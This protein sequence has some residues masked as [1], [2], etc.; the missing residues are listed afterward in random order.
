MTGKE[1]Y[2]K[3]LKETECRF[4]NSPIQKK[5]LK[6]D[7][8]WYYSICST[9]IKK[10]LPV[11]FGINPGAKDSVDYKIKMEMP[12]T[13]NEINDY[14]FIKYISPFLEEYTNLDLND[15]NFNYTNLCFFRSHSIRDLTHVDYE[16]SIP[17]FKKYL[18]YINP[19]YIL[20]IGNK[21]INVL[22]KVAKKS[23]KIVDIDIHPI[24]DSLKK[25][26]AYSGRLWGWSLYSVPHPN[27]HIQTQSR[28]ELWGKI[29]HLIN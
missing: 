2:K 3:L 25:Y 8:E 12:T 5:Q 6:N 23:P 14:R 4:Q 16:I 29:K 10:E 28:K 9:P 27:F 13:G 22:S 7:H 15:I 20:S 11:L 17:L 24:F 21:N 1:F 19:P 26:K 18:E